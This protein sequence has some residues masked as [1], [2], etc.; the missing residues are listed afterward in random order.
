MRHFTTVAW[1]TPSF[2]A[3]SLFVAPVPASR[4]MRERTANDCGLFGLRAHRSNVTRS[5]SVNTS[6]AFGRPRVAIGRHY[7][8]QDQNASFF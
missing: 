8:N 1:F 4:M 6:G 5:S 2:A 3:T 7:D